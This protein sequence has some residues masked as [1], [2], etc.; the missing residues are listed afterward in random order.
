MTFKHQSFVFSL[1]VLYYEL[2][3]SKINGNLVLF[4]LFWV[5]AA[6]FQSKLSTHGSNLNSIFVILSELEFFLLTR[7]L[8]ENFNTMDLVK[9]LE[10]KSKTSHEDQVMI[11]SLIMNEL[12]SKIKCLIL[13]GHRD[14]YYFFIFRFF[15]F[16]ENKKKIYSF[17][18]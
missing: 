8:T 6:H 2:L 14:V 12:K 17:Y 11:I 3:Y 1:G 10:K 4:S 15:I 9:S 18:V 5:F 16:L 13:V 7:V